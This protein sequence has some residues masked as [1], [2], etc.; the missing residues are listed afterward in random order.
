MTDV[1]DAMSFFISLMISSGG[2]HFKFTSRWF[3]HIT[4]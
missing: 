1:A 4:L 2:Y 3:Q